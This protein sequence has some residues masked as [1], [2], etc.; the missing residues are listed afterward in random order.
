MPKTSCDNCKYFIKSRL[1][2]WLNRCGHP[3]T[4]IFIRSEIAWYSNKC[5]MNKKLFEDKEKLVQ[6]EP[7][8]YKAGSWKS[9]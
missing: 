9:E 2:K 6:I 7:L 3:E 5:G 8:K 1:L 4:K